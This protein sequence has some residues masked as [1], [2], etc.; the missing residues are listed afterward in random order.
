MLRR[1]DI[2][3]DYHQFYLRDRDVAPDAPIDYVDADVTRRIKAA[4][5]I[6]VL[7]PERDMTVPLELETFDAE[8]PLDLDAWDH[9]AE[10][11]LDLPS[12]L[13]ELHECTGGSIDVLQLSPGAYRV[14][15]CGARLDTLSEDTLDGDDRYRTELWPAPAAPV[16][17][18]KQFARG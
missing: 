8:P 16:A 10:A 9:V 12:G 4:P 3:A 13:L 18:L 11:G 15:F 7:Q 17:V 14:R 1:Y 5:F 2:F 6:V